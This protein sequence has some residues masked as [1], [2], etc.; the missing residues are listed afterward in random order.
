MRKA[1]GRAGSQRNKAGGGVNHNAC[2]MLS[3][4]ARGALSGPA[5]RRFVAAKSAH[6]AADDGRHRSAAAA[7]AAARKWAGALGACASWSVKIQAAT[8]GAPPPPAARVKPTSS[9]RAALRPGSR[10]PALARSLDVENT[11]AAT[12]ITAPGR[13]FQSHLFPLHGRAPPVGRPAGGDGGSCLF[14][15]LGR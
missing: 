6:G 3:G 13:R 4:G 8:S 2:N 10:L 11:S 9:R 14:A 15:E 12:P 7:A 5:A 1:L